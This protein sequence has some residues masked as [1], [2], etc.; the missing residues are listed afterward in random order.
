MISIINKIPVR[1]NPPGLIELWSCQPYIWTRIQ[2]LPANGIMWHEALSANPVLHNLSAIEPK[3]GY[4]EAHTYTTEREDPPTLNGLRQALYFG[5][6]MHN[7]HCSESPT[8][9]AQL[10][11][12][13]KTTQY[14]RVRGQTC[15]SDAFSLSK[16]SSDELSSFKTPCALLSHK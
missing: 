15:A 13:P 9:A 14:L 4:C 8:Q 16:N 11:Q 12:E 10:K 1:A 5:M 7:N 2:K 6:H 3:V